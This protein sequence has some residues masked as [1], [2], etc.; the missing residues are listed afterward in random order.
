M[1]VKIKTAT[2]ECIALDAGQS[3]GNGAHSD[4]AT[5][6]EQ[7]AMRACAPAK[8]DFTAR[9]RRPRKLDKAVMDVILARIAGGEL[10]INI[11]KDPGTPARNTVY[12]WLEQ[13]EDMRKRYDAALK[14]R[15][16][17]FDE[18]MIVIA[19]SVKE[20][21]VTQTIGKT[22]K[23]NL[24]KDRIA[25][26]KLRIVARSIVRGKTLRNQ[27]GDGEEDGVFRVINSPDLEESRDADIA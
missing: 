3:Q 16:D 4:E 18:D 6:S 1:S 7:A 12:L 8:K 20:G 9:K 5:P 17:Y 13:D 2:G 26:A 24:A 27:E 19:D 10:L 25:I 15:R 11:V 23:A 14:A 22:T 21:N